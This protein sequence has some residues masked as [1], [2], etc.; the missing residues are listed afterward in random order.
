MT[1][2]GNCSYSGVT[3]MQLD[4]GTC[5]GNDSCGLL[6]LS[7]AAPSGSA[8][9]LSRGDRRL[10]FYSDVAFGSIIAN[11]AWN[12]TSRLHDGPAV[13][14][15]DGGN[16]FPQRISSICSG[17]SLPGWIPS[18][19]GSSTEHPGLHLLLPP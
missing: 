13:F 8:F 16:P 9:A 17:A 5:S 6:I 15:L 19:D 14:H 3:F 2:G 12:N 11:V 1:W 10:L 18:P 7:W 4:M